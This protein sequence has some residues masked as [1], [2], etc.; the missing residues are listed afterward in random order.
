[1]SRKCP[2]DDQNS[3]LK[4][5]NG[6]KMNAACSFECSRKFFSRV[7]VSGTC[8]TYYQIG[9]FELWN[10]RDLLIRMFEKLLKEVERP[11]HFLHKPP[12]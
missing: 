3:W 8:P 2:L 11:Q 9:C 5:V 7:I 1:M 4:L 6:H 12:A 10:G